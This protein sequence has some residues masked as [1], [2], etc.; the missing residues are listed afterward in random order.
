ME[1]TIHKYQKLILP[2]SYH[3]EQY[4]M[5]QNKVATPSQFSIT[6]HRIGFINMKRIS[7][8]QMVIKNLFYRDR[9]EK[10][11]SPH[12]KASWTYDM[13]YLPPTEHLRAISQNTKPIAQ[14][15]A[16]LNDSKCFM[17]MESSRTSGAMYLD[18]KTNINYWQ[19]LV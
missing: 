9:V 6:L 2:K 15:S 10:F 18:G 13:L 11:S 8:S 14:I 3:N 17:F 1:I 16:L 5:H 7:I 19:T 12:A 4:I